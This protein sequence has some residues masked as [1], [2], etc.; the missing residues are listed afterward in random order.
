MYIIIFKLAKQIDI[1]LNTKYIN[2]QYNYD[3][4]KNI[5]HI[6]NLYL[7]WQNQIVNNK[8]LLINQFM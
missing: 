4:M 6:L 5:L 7:T 2:N 8:L 3:F 1:I